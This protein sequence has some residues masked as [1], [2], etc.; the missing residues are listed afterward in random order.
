VEAPLSHTARQ[1]GQPHLPSAHPQPPPSA[2]TEAAAEI[3][4]AAPGQDATPEPDSA[5]AITGRRPDE[6]TL[7]FLLKE[8]VDTHLGGILLLINL[9]T[10][11]DLPG[12]FR[13]TWLPPE[14]ISPWATL[15]AIARG[16]ITAETPAGPDTED[17]PIWWILAHIDGREPG[18]P[19]GSTLPDAPTPLPPFRLPPSWLQWLPADPAGLRWS[20]SAGR[21]QAWLTDGSLLIDIAAEDDDPHGALALELKELNLPAP[22]IPPEPP[23]EPQQLPDLHPLLTAWLARVIP[24]LRSILGYLLALQPGQSLTAALLQIPARLYVTAS[25]IDLVIRI[26]SASLPIRRVGL[27]RSPGWLRPIG[28]VIHIHFL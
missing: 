10:S 25:H 2:G 4:H 5:Q 20:A 11:L 19:P 27:D 7:Q 9:M 28:R 12:A 26:E 14:S 18:Q 15:D 22:T 6:R 16:L 24:T 23:P 13:D 8:G 3:T 17:D 1:P 21:L